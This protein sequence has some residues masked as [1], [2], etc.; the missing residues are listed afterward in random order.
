MGLTKDWVTI[1]PA[2]LDIDEYQPTIVNGE[3]VTRQS[4]INTMSIASQGLQSLVGSDNLEKYSLRE[5]IGDN[6]DHDQEFPGPT[7]PTDGGGTWEEATF[8]GSISFSYSDGV[9]VSGGSNARGASRYLIDPTQGGVEFWCH[10][11]SNGSVG[12]NATI[13]LISDGG[14]AFVNAGLDRVAASD[15]RLTVF[16]SV[17]NPVIQLGIGNV[18]NAWIRL[19][20]DGFVYSVFYSLN[21]EASEPADTGW[22]HLTSVSYQKALEVKRFSIEG[23]RFSAGASPDTVGKHARIRFW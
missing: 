8:E 2:E 13:G 16:D 22:T 9:T 17:T 20:Y 21:A 10:L 1:Y 19:R 3:D 23:A 4:Q 14:T 5:Q 18:N 7:I 6:F 15:W 11:T 12:S